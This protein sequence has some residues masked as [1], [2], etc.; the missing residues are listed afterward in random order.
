MIQ[1]SVVAQ[2]SNWKECI[3]TIAKKTER[4]RVFSLF[5]LSVDKAI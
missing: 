5:D 2:Q 1:R 3:K 4:D